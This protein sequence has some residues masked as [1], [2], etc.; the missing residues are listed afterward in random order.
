MLTAA[1]GCEGLALARTT[2]CNA[3]LLDVSMPEMDGIAT[4]QHLQADP[5][6]RSVPTI[7]L[8]AKATATEYQ[9][10]LQLGVVGVITKPFKAKDL[11]AQIRTLLYWD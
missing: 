8:T 1:S 2:P 6:L 7:F 10:L 4:L 5:S 11:V 3:I 9:S